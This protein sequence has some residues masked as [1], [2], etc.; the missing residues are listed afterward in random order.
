[1]PGLRLDGRRAPVAG[2]GHG[3]GLA[4]AA[5][6]ADA[7]A[8]VTLVARTLAEI[9]A[10]SEAIRARGGAAEAVALD[11]TDLAAV[12]SFLEAGETHDVLVNNADAN[13]PAPMAEAMAADFDLVMGL[14]M[15]AAGLSAAGRAKIA[16][17]ATA[18]RVAP[19]GS[20]GS[21]PVCA[22]PISLA[23]WTATP[24]AGMRRCARS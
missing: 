17:F 14:K 21:R 13:R 16:A 6:L 23:A 22:L 15:R 9:E 2:A 4:C 8:R 20:T 11:V 24:T 19:A 5:A 3:L 7:G 1:M 10:A 18:L 12:S